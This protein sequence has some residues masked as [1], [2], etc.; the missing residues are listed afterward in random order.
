MALVFLSLGRLA[1]APEFRAALAPA[2][3]VRVREPA[4]AQAK[5]PAWALALVAVQAGVQEL[6]E[7]VQA[8]EVVAPAACASPSRPGRRLSCL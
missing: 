6:E 5:G 3:Q 7:T 1:A 8:E 4:Q 2:P